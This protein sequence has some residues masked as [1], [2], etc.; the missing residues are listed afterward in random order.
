M[1]IKNECTQ[2]CEIQNVFFFIS[3]NRDLTRLSQYNG[4]GHILF[5]TCVMFLGFGKLGGVGKH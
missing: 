1:Q 3:Q 4:R 2:V 5:Q